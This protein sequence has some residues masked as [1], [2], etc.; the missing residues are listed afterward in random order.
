MADIR[1]PEG[2]QVE[3]GVGERRGDYPGGIINGRK[4]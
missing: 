3:K 2:Y 1:Y 4:A